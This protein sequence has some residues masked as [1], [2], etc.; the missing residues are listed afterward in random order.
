MQ[1]SPLNKY[2][3][4]VAAVIRP[5]A[6]H[7]I[8]LLAEIVASYVIDSEA[9]Y[10]QKIITSLPGLVFTT[11][12]WSESKK[13]VQ[14][15][16][17]FTR[18]GAVWQVGMSTAPPRGSIRQATQGMI[19]ESRVLELFTDECFSYLPALLRINSVDNL[20]HNELMGLMAKLLAQVG[21]AYVEAPHPPI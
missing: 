21:R 16:V 18:V 1:Q 13:L 5:L 20:P 2:P 3:A 17:G 14:G 8:G 11:R 12:H 9:D 15:T 4:F 19:D 10:V 7:L 6:G